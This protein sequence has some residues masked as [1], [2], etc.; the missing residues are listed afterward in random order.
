MGLFNMF[1]KKSSR[2]DKVQEHAKSQMSPRVSQ[3]VHASYRDNGERLKAAQTLSEDEI[4]ECYES[5]FLLMTMKSYSEQT[6]QVMSIAAMGGNP[7]ACVRMGFLQP[8]IE[9]A[10]KDFCSVEDYRKAK[11]ALVK[12]VGDY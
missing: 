3:V 9:D 8:S 7:N 1:S 2:E 10:W 4:Q 12:L 6:L 11:A 5:A